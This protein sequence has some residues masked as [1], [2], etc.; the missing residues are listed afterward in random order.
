MKFQF[1]V[2]KGLVATGVEASEEAI[3]GWFVF[4]QVL[5][6]APISFDYL[7]AEGGCFVTLFCNWSLLNLIINVSSCSASCN[8]NGR[9]NL[10]MDNLKLCGRAIAAWSSAQVAPSVVS[11]IQCTR[12]SAAKPRPRWEM[13][14]GSL[15]KWKRRPM[16]CLEAW[17]CNSICI[18]GLSAQNVPPN[19]MKSGIEAVG[20][21]SHECTFWEYTTFLDY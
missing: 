18:W 14:N 21:S 12:A 15:D 10:N 20:G 5:L 6:F 13:A 7:A 4:L 1:S 9:F 16:W 3:S 19:F 11:L 8:L 17:N 2:W